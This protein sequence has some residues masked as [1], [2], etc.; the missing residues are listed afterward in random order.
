[1]ELKPVFADPSAPTSKAE[2]FWAGFSLEAEGSLY[3][4]HQATQTFRSLGTEGELGLS[5][6]LHQFISPQISLSR[7]GNMSFLPQPCHAL[8]L[9]ELNVS[10]FLDT[11]CRF[12]GSIR[13]IFQS[14]ELICATLAKK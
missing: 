6:S 8:C 11:I 7:V 13:Y 4:P 12:T 3:C 9:A 10:P 2:V 1:M 14:R 5:P